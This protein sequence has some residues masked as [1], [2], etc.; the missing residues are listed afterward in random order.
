MIQKRFVVEKK[1]ILGLLKQGCRFVCQRHGAPLRG[2]RPRPDHAGKIA[3]LYCR[4]C[5]KKKAWIS[6]YRH[7]PEKAAPG[8]QSSGDIL[9]YRTS[10]EVEAVV[11][12]PR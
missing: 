12:L 10:A 5:D 4:E 9:N 7:S 3:Y 1:L 8:R 6:D 11:H 2:G